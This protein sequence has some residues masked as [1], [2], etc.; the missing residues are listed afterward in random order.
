MKIIDD[1][2]QGTPEWHAVRCGRATASEFSAVLAKDQGKTRAAY[3]RKVVAERLTGKVSEGYTNKHMER[4][5]ELEPMARFAYE[6]TFD[7]QVRRVGF[8]QHDELMSGCSPDG[9]V[10]DDG[11]AEIKCVLPH[12]QV[13]TMLSG[14]YPTEH[15]PQVQGGLWLSGRRWWDFVSYCPEMRDPR[16]RLYRFRVEPDPVYIK[17]LEAEVRLFLADVDRAL[18]QLNGQDV[19]SLLRKSIERVA[20]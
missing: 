16:H 3:L 10:D 17:T 4:G 11:G 12:V 15:R 6:A 2:E 18:V 14:S 1:I 9:L 13:D 5:Q 19:E 7:V 8:I 20:A